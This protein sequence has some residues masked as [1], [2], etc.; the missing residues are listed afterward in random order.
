MHFWGASLLPHSAPVPWLK[1]D[2]VLMDL[3]K[4]MRHTQDLR[5]LFKS[6]I[7]HSEDLERE[8]KFI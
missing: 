2:H 4:H 8:E 3:S 6:L 7:R 5:F 1:G